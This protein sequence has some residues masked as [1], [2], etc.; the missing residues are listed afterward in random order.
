MEKSIIEKAKEWLE[1]LY[2]RQTRDEVRR[3]M[4]ED[5]A[6][7]EDSFYKNLEFGTGGLRGIMGV[8]TNRMNRYTVGMVT[9]GLAEYVRKRTRDLTRRRSL[10]IAETSP[11]NL[12]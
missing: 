8:G 5:P 2:D 12:P 6:L 3:L 9:Q 11:L 1:P 4:E 10:T 7:L